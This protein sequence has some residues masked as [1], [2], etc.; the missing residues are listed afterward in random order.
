MSFIFPLADA[1]LKLLGC[2]RYQTRVKG[3]LMPPI[4]KN[5]L[6]KTGIPQI[7]I[8][9][10]VPNHALKFISQVSK[11]FHCLLIVILQFFLT[12]SD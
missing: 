10:D 6:P 1:K 9:V 5:I 11:V 8:L 2:L 7:L 4:P 12:H 3:D